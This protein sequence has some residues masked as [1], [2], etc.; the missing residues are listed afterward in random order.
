MS[1]DTQREISIVYT[2]LHGVGKETFV[3]VFEK[4]GFEDLAIV[5]AQ[6]D[7]D[8]DF[9]TFLFQTQKRTLDL[10]INCRH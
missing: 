2:P 4:V 8:P 6:T 9:P 5:A 1:S 10:A 7:P 3:Q